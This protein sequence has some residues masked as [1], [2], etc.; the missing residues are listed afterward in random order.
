MTF[1][2]AVIRAAAFNRRVAAQAAGRGHATVHRPQQALPLG[3]LVARLTSGQ[4]LQ[5]TAK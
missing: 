2:E 1:D 3:P 5:Q 4:K